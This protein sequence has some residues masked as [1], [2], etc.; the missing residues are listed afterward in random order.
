MQP[1]LLSGGSVLVNPSI[2]KV[3]T[4]LIKNAI[5]CHVSDAYACFIS[6]YLDPGV[7]RIMVGLV[8]LH[9][10]LFCNHYSDFET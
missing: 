2:Q 9:L 10:Q 1:V 8:E 7:R 3:R 6:I 4:K 5:S